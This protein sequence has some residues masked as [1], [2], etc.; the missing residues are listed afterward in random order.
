MTS[1]VDLTRVTVNLDTEQ[2]RS[3]NDTIHACYVDWK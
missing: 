1:D 3:T 2:T